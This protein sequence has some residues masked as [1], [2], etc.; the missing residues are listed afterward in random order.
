MSV[1][2]VFSPNTWGSQALSLPW[3]YLLPPQLILLVLQLL[4]LVVL[5]FG[6]DPTQVQGY[7]NLFCMEI[8]PEV[9]VS[10]ELGELGADDESGGLQVLCTRVRPLPSCLFFF[11]LKPSLLIQMFSFYSHETTSTYEQVFFVHT[12]SFVL[13]YRT[14]QSRV[15]LPHSL[16]PLSAVKA[17][18]GDLT[19]AVPGIDEAMSFA[20]LMKQVC[21][22]SRKCVS[23][24]IPLWP[25]LNAELFF[26]ST[27]KT[28]EA[29]C[30][31]F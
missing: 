29:Y 22:R 25:L 9:D 5:Q 23:V 13:S 14:F 26:T 2:R 31:H 12:A 10:D 3:T 30:W 4:L 19:K 15:L 20:E 11:T 8:D 17:M 21:Y 24:I 16:S 1:A 7:D 18:M 28:Q 6:K 27:R